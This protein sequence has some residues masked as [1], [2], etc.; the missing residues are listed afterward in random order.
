MVIKIY[1]YLSHMDLWWL[2]HDFMLAIQFETRVVWTMFYSAT[3]KNSYVYHRSHSLSKTNYSLKKLRLTVL[4]KATRSL[5]PFCAFTSSLHNWRLTQCQLRH[6]WLWKLQ[7]CFAW[8][9]CVTMLVLEACMYLDVLWILL[10]LLCGQ[11]RSKKL[12]RFIL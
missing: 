4:Q 6:Q 2:I 12:A 11:N 5:S 3:R 7:L 9:T 10:C 8:E 1:S